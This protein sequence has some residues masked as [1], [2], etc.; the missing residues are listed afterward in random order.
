MLKRCEYNPL[1][2]PADVIPSD[3][4][5]QVDGIF[6]CGVAQY[7]DEIILLCRVA[8]SVK[9]TDENKIEIPV[10]VNEDGQDVIKTVVYDK[11]EQPE[12]DY[13]DSRSVFKVGP[14]GKKTTAYLTES[15]LYW[16]KN[17]VSCR[18]RPKNHGGWK[19]PGLRR[20]E[21]TTISVTP[22]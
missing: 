7:R 4:R 6:N 5:F 14:K 10:V 9:Q 17:L 19:I 20:S 16:T 12:F 1:L 8:E 18:L 21:R 22:L 11:K 3:P 15:I 13:S 2:T